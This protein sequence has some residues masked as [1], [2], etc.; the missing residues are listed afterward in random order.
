MQVM[1][2]LIAGV[3]IFACPIVCA[4]AMR[5][6]CIAIVSSAIVLTV[7]VHVTGYLG[8]GYVDPFFTVSIPVGIG[9]FLLWSALVVWIVRRLLLLRD[10]SHH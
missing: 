3:A 8:A 10:K 6:F 1:W 2:N 4:L 7:V 9:A 5:S